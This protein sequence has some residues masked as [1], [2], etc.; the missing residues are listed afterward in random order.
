MLE[1][2]T[3][4][5]RNGPCSVKLT[6]ASLIQPTPRP[7]R[8]VFLA[9]HPATPRQLILL[10]VL[11]TACLF[12]GEYNPSPEHSPRFHNETH[13]CS[14]S[15]RL[16]NPEFRAQATTVPYPRPSPEK[17]PAS[18]LSPVL[19]LALL[20]NPLGK[21]RPIQDGMIPKRVGHPCSPLTCERC[22]IR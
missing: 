16:L 9:C 7:P 5:T 8:S 18:P 1:L 14:P 17:T 6:S 4:S 15:S 3:C 13:C 12:I 19:F 20:E 22:I 10:P 2:L 21:P 11:G